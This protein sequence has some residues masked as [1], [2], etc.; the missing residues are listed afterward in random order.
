MMKKLLSFLCAMLFV[1]VI[2][3]PALA[4]LYDEGG[5]LIYDDV[6]EITFRPHPTVN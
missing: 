5:G 2:S 4:T 3:S 6:L 1:F